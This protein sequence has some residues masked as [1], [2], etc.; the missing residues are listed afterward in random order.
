[1]TGVEQRAYFATGD[2]IRYLCGWAYRGRVHLE[3]S[4]SVELTPQEARRAAE[5]LLLAAARAEEH[6]RWLTGR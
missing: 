2:E 1:M 4:R 5:S 6:A 3:A